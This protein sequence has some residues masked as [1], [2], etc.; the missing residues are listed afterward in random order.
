MTAALLQAQ[1]HGVPLAEILRSQAREM[2]VKKKQ[3]TE[4]KAAKL[5]VKR[6]F[7]VLLC[8]MPVFFVILVGPSLAGLRGVFS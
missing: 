2:R 6:V 4:E 1:R 7:P 5:G 8:F 3:R